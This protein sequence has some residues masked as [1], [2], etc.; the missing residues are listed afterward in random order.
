MTL[1]IFINKI[2][3]TD[4]IA[5]KNKLSNGYILCI[6]FTKDK[7]SPS[8]LHHYQDVDGY[9]IHSSPKKDQKTIFNF[10]VSTF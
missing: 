4:K 2:N 10:F 9:Y 7:R 3:T 1:P 8:Y 6:V 5:T